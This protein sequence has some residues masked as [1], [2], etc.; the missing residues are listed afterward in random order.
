LTPA[1]KW[2]K[3]KSPSAGRW[4]ASCSAELELATTLK[5]QSIRRAWKS[6]QNDYA[7]LLR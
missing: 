4:T 7:A 2:I 3:L 6:D 1:L 5:H